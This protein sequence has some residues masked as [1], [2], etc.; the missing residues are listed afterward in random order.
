V[1]QVDKSTAGNGGS[2]PAWRRYLTFWRTP[3]ARDVDDEL[4]FHMNMR[5]KEFMARGM[6]EDDALRAVAERLGDVPAARAECIELGRVR[7][8]NARA[9]GFVDDLVQ[10]IRFAGRQFRRNPGF[11]A[12]AIV[13]LALGIGANTAIFSVVHHVLLDPLPFPDG[14][15]IVA[16]AL[17]PAREPDPRFQFVFDVPTSAMRR[18]QAQS[19]TVTEVSAVSVENNTVIAR[20]TRADTWTERRSARRSSPCFAFTSRWAARSTPEM[21]AA[22]RRRWH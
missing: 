9:A 1:S 17:G 11:A 6:S 21:L 3:I 2:T 4:R 8:R 22:A 12:L 5:M 20:G 15:R 16:F 14:N 13:T 10:D 19:A 7:E 18:L